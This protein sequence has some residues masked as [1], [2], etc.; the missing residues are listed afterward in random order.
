MAPRHE[1]TSEKR[2]GAADLI[3]STALARLAHEL[4]AFG[5]A[6]KINT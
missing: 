5:S 2:P 6:A 4:P 3:E 1:H